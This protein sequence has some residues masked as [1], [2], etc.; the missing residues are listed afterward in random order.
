MV[1]SRVGNVN[2]HENMLSNLTI[3]SYLK[4]ISNLRK[5]V[6]MRSQ[7]GC[8]FV[9]DASNSRISS[10][11]LPHILFN[12]WQMLLLEDGGLTTLPRPIHIHLD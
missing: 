1:G 5:E 11:T 2:I 4:A 12:R 7:T 10:S 8:V 6:R 3:E 9:D